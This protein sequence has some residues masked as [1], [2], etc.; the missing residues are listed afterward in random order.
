MIPETFDDIRSLRHH[1]DQLQLNCIQ[2]ILKLFGII[3]ISIV[4]SLIYLDTATSF[5][6]GLWITSLLSPST[7]FH[8]PTPLS[9]SIYSQCNSKTQTISQSNQNPPHKHSTVPISLRSWADRG[10][11]SLQAHP[12]TLSQP[13]INITTPPLVSLQNNS[14]GTSLTIIKLSHIITEP[15]RISTLIDIWC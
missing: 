15:L 14:L 11:P 1:S 12:T 8:S 6:Y 9:N 7:A 4:H 10:N 13:H 3:C 2:H 5:I